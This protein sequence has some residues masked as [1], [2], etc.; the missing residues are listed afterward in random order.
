MFHNSSPTAG[1]FR[2][3][4]TVWQNDALSISSKRYGRSLIPVQSSESHPRSTIMP[5]N[6]FGT[7]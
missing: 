2:G 1:S 5:E 6:K 3:L 7:D 4:L